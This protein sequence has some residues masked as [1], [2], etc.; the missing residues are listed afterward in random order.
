MKAKG[1][2]VSIITKNYKPSCDKGM[3]PWLKTSSSSQNTSS[4]TLAALLDELEFNKSGICQFEESNS[5]SL[6]M[7]QEN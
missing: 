1:L 4:V 3:S 6:A 7:F 5:I 2:T